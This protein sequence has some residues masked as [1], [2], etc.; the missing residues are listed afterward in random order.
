MLCPHGNSQGN[1]NATKHGVENSLKGTEPISVHFPCV[2]HSIL[3]S[4]LVSSRGLL[5]FSDTK[6]LVSTSSTYSSTVNHLRTLHLKL[7]PNIID[8][9]V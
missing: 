5:S 3:C 7:L 6:I 1:A 8:Y 4:N 9:F 2:L